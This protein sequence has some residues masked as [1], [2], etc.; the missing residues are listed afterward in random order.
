MQ[1]VI[2][3]TRLSLNSNLSVGPAQDCHVIPV[4]YYGERAF[5]LSQMAKV[6][7]LNE[8]GDFVRSKMQT[9]GANYG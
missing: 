7:K 6:L 9:F 2:L 1:Y 8:T 3:A 5:N 4:G